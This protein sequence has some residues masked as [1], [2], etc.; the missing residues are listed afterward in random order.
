MKTSL[1]ASQMAEDFAVRLLCLSV[2]L[3]LAT[4]VVAYTYY[5]DPESCGYWYG[6]AGDYSTK[7]SSPDT[8]GIRALADSYKEYS[9]C[10]GIVKSAWTDWCSGYDSVDGEAYYYLWCENSIEGYSGDLAIVEVVAELFNSTKS[11]ANSTVHPYETDYRDTDYSYPAEANF[12]PAGSQKFRVYLHASASAFGGATGSYSHSDFYNGEKKLQV[13]EF[14]V[15]L[16][17]K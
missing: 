13:Q 17:G 10:T 11:L 15:D 12:P 16:Y 9:S 2:S 4:I 7:S 14:Y 3:S 8:I 1:K 5:P 6:Q